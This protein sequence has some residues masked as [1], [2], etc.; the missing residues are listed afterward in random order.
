MCRRSLRIS[1]VPCRSWPR[2]PFARTFHSGARSRWV[3][4]AISFEATLRRWFRRR[5]APRNQNSPSAVLAA[6]GAA[7]V[8]AGGWSDGCLHR[9][10]STPVFH[11]HVHL[12]SHRLSLVPHTLH[13]LS[14]TL[15]QQQA[16]VGWASPLMPNAVRA[17]ASCGW[18]RRRGQYAPRLGAEEKKS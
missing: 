8:A 9:E 15:H 2:G 5:M 13:V 12:I 7:A 17:G 16:R 1:A 11:V 6:D 4:A 3:R 18:P 14:G 10:T